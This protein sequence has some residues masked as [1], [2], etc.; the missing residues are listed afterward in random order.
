M[1]PAGFSGSNLAI[2]AG[3]VLGL[4]RLLR[5]DPRAAA[6]LSAAA[7]LGFVVL[8]RP[9]PS[10]LRA[11]AMGGVALLALALGRQ[12][13][14][15]PAL[16]AAVLGLLLVDPALAVDPGFALSALATAALVLVAPGWAAGLRRGGVPQ[17]VAEALAVRAAACVATAPV[18]AGLSGGVSLV[19]VAANL[20]AVPAVAPATVL[21]VVAALVSPVS[22]P[23]AQACAWAAGPAVAWLV[24]VA[25]RA[26]AVPG[27]V[28][29]WP[30]GVAGS[31]LLVAVVVVV[32]R[33]ARSRRIRPLLLAALV[34]LLLVLVPTRV[35]R[36]GWPPRGWAV[37]AC[38]VGQGDA[39]VLATG[40][41]GRAV[42]V[43]AGPDDGPVDACLRRL[44]ITALALVVISHLHADHVG[45]LAG[46]LR[47]RSVGA[48]AVGP[49]HEP[50]PALARVR[51]QAAAAGAPVVQVP[52]GAR[53]AWPALVLDVLGPQHPPE[54]VDP[55][56]GTQ[57]NDGSVVLRA[58]TGA[59]SVLLS[60]DVEVA[61]QAQ[62][63]ASGVPL[64]A[65][66]LKMPHGGF[67]Q[68][69]SHAAETGGFGLNLRYPLALTGT[70]DLG[71][72]R[73]ACVR[74][75]TCALTTRLR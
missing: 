5:A 65:D 24:A 57:V 61:A 45:G 25:D 74:G 54:H 22:P 53:L 15:V 9:S 14:A 59:G 36:P 37:V 17:G 55:D 12:R 28:V 56:D 31:A 10:V 26:A 3:A 41:E 60:G 62:L 42:L 16:A 11:A 32:G 71:P 75:G 69:V 47:G 68:V 67:S 29:P 51:R 73:S 35:V 13:S 7:L 44:G 52:L 2:V 6:A 66:V 30:T 39:L 46:A 33:L 40:E 58:V 21:G 49:V 34:G 4:L 8:A 70:L 50:V 63:L 20:L 38:D 23:A 1:C 48:V 72:R 27:A 43:A 19:T 64:Q 18:I